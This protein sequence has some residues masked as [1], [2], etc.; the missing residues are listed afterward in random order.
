MAT[1]SL[2]SQAP[3][4]RLIAAITV[5]RLAC[6]AGQSAAT[7]RAQRRR[8]ECLLDL[9]T[10][11]LFTISQYVVVTDDR[12]DTQYTVPRNQGSRCS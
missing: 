2:R 10:L 5:A 1:L 4:S 6:E 11:Q 12:F 3:C 9:E 8:V 7:S